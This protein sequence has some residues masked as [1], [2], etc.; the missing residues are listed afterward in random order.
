MT[1]YNTNNGLSI[2]SMLITTAICFLAIVLAAV[3][4]LPNSHA[5]EAQSKVSHVAKPCKSKHAGVCSNKTLVKIASNT[6][7]SA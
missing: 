4:F 2:Q 1:A 3:L 7:S 5:R 6:S